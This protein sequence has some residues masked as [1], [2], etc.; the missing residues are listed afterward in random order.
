MIVQ[1][2][3]YNSPYIINDW[4]TLAKVKTKRNEVTHTG[5]LQM[6]YFGP[7]LPPSLPPCLSAFDITFPCP[8]TDVHTPVNY[9]GLT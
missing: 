1:S 7:A 8:F 2:I 6:T 3:Y 4:M 9:E 5:C